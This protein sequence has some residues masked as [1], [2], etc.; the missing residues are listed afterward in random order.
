[1]V[2]G[3]VSGGQRAQAA[4]QVGDVALPDGQDGGEGQDDEAAM[5]RAREGWF[6][7]IEDTVQRPGQLPAEVLEL[8]S[9]GP[10]L[11]VVLASPRSP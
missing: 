7:G 3:G 8:A 1:M 10:G 4:E 9:R 5:G 6:Q 2:A 11:S